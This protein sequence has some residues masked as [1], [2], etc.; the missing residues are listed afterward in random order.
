MSDADHKAAIESMFRDSYA[1]VLSGLA[2]RFRD[3][4]LAEEGIQDAR[5]YAPGR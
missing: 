1:V 3:I 5:R 2:T 4:D